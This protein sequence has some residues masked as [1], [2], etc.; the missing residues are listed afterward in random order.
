MYFRLQLDNISIY[1]CFSEKN[2]VCGMHIPDRAYLTTCF[3]CY[4]FS[5]SK[6]YLF[7]VLVKTQYSTKCLSDVLSALRSKQ[8]INENNETKNFC[9]ALS[10]NDY[11]KTMC[12]NNIIIFHCSI[13]HSPLCS[14][15]QSD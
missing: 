14:K 2:R 13:N 10:D 6:I 15:F 12:F 3:T 8:K 1:E 7:Q 5:L 4:K 9:S 11:N